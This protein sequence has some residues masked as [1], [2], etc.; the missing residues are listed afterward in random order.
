MCGTISSKHEIFKIKFCRIPVTSQPKMP[1]SIGS[2]EEMVE[3]VIS[4]LGDIKNN[5]QQMPHK[6]SKEYFESSMQN[7]KL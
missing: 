1:N 7:I 4:I 5:G 2:V 6:K 3:Q